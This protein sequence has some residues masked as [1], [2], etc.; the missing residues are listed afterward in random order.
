MGNPLGDYWKIYRDG[1][2]MGRR[3][4]NGAGIACAGLKRSVGF[5]IQP[6]E[7]WSRYPELNTV[8][9]LLRDIGE[10][11]RVLDLGSPKML[12]LLLAQRH[13]AAF[14][15]TDLWETAVDEVRELVRSNRDR[16][17]GT[18][19]LATADLT[20]LADHGDGEFDWVY[21]ISVIEHIEDLEAVRTGLRE[22]A[23]VLKPGGQAVVSVPVAPVYRAEFHARSVYGKGDDQT[24]VFFSHYFD[25]TTLASVL[26]SVPQLRL[27]RL[28]YSRWHDGK[29]LLRV[30]TRVPQRIR[31]LLG[32]VNLFIAPSGATVTEEPWDNLRID[33]SGDVI[34]R[35][36]RI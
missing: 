34:M 33:G 2:A 10:N 23:R 4:F 27:S 16:L 22:M 14:R 11:E 8:L 28:H 30:W 12:G 29:P 20:D 7:N 9:D 15:L 31:G 24:E 26:A 21:S 1:S 35:F 13:A 32:L 17:S 5:V 3:H 25:R 6:V 19:E 18:V 36:E